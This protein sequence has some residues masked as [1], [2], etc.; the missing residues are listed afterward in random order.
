[1][2]AGTCEGACAGGE[3]RNEEGCKASTTKR[4]LE[5]SLKKL[6]LEKPLNKITVTDICEDCGISRMTFYYHFQDIYDLVEWSCQEDAGK[7]LAGNRTVDTWQKGLLSIFNLVR[8][9]RPFV[10]NVYRCVSRERVER[11]LYDITYGL[12]RAVVDEKAEGLQVREEDKRFVAGFFRY[13]FVG[14]MLDW[15]A[16]DMKDD[17]ETLVHKIDTIIHGDFRSALERFAL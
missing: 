14:V 12:L 8:E 3:D 17:P 10:M 5:S 1:M 16:G 6:L 13:A 9:N 2:R 7:A 4:A 15:V 11:Y